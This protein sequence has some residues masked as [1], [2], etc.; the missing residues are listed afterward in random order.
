MDALIYVYYFNNSYSP[1]PVH[2]PNDSPSQSV[3]M[4]HQGVQ[5]RIAVTIIYEEGAPTAPPLE[6][7]ECPK[8]VVGRA[9]DTPEFFLSDAQTR[10][11]SLSVFP[12]HYLPPAG[13][14]RLVFS[15]FNSDFN[16]TLK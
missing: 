2:R 9:R 3:F 10:I 14:D 5:R 7:V 13:D 12:I 8:V 11:L 1:V 4:L 6:F 15:G 16:S